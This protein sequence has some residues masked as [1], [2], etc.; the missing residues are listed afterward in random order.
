MLDVEALAELVTCDPLTG[1]LFWTDKAG[2]KRPAGK[3]AFDTPMEGYRYGKIGKQSLMAHRVVWLLCTG[4]W[5]DVI[6]HINGNRS[7]NRFENL[8]S[9]STGVNARNASK[10]SNNTTGCTG[11]SREKRNGKWKAYVTVNGKTVWLGCN[12][13]SQ[14]AACLVRRT[15]ILAHP[16][17]GFTTRHGGSCEHERGVSHEAQCG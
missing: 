1:S 3:R 6:D 15:H 5:P 14:E 10:P 17:Y 9:V 13:L 12:H 7:D 8:R 4:E 11:V 2:P 16:E